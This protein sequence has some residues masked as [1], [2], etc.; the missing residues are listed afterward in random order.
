MARLAT[1]RLLAAASMSMSSIAAT[2][3]AALVLLVATPAQ[4]DLSYAFFFGEPT[5]S[6]T[7]NGSVAYDS[8]QG[9]YTLTTGDDQVGSLW[10]NSKQQV[11]NGFHT[12]FSFRIQPGQLLGDGF[13]F[14]LQNDSAGTAS[15][16]GGGSGLGYE[17]MT[18]TLAIEFDTFSFG[19][20]AEFAA[21]HVAVHSNGLGAASAGPDG[22][23]AVAALPFTE[24]RLYSDMNVAITYVPR[25]PDVPQ[26]TGRLEVW[27]EEQLLI[28]LAIDLD[29]MTNNGIGGAQIT[30]ANGEMRMGFTASTGLADSAHVIT[31][32]TVRD[33][34]G[35][36]CIPPQWHLAST[37]SGFDGTNYTNFNADVDVSGTRPLAFQWYKDDVAMTADG[38][39]IQGFQS[40]RL[41]MSPLNVPGD[42][43]YYRLGATNACG[44]LAMDNFMRF[45]PPDTCSDID[46]NND[47]LFPDDNDLVGFLNV[48]AG[49]P[50]PGSVC[51]PI[52]YNNDG[53]FPDDSDLIA[54]L[55]VLAGGSCGG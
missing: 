34:T 21:P 39:R 30:D 47:G 40:P 24:S 36:S 52:D 18:N 22:Q 5:E 49:G 1:L 23:L 32:W 20:P 28:N 12:I 27:V 42:I 3:S 7:K 17:G 43:G 46:F 25:D 33:N 11:S 48:L 55:R 41:A 26:S 14:V 37:G 15:L 44:T 2:G 13:A 31:D 16:G 29:N 4:A 35:R 38:G 19:P 8:Q 54:F 53:L 51:D 9:V 6:F 50:C 45:A 10:H